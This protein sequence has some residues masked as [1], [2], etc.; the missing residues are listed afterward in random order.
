DNRTHLKVVVQQIENAFF[1]LVFHDL[2]K[3]RLAIRA[4][5]LVHRERMIGLIPGAELFGE[6]AN[7]LW[8]QVQI[9]KVLYKSSLDQIEETKD[10]SAPNSRQ[11]PLNNRGRAA[12][13]H[14]VDPRSH[15]NAIF[16]QDPSRHWHGVEADLAD[17]LPVGIVGTHC[18]QYD[19][20]VFTL[21]IGDFSDP[22]ATREPSLRRF[23]CSAV[24]R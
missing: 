8:R 9:P 1:L 10:R 21:G 24:L 20:D 7:G 11:L 2:H 4:K 5:S 3:N 17:G 12:V 23:V 15:A 19:M 18:A 13:L 22:F 6:L 16:A 14:A